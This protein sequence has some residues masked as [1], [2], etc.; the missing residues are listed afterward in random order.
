MSMILS[1][2]EDIG[3]VYYYEWVLVLMMKMGRWG[4]RVPSEV[5][6]VSSGRLVGL[7]GDF[8]L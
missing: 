5:E 8:G 1:G 3:R 7:F 4:I 2:Y 6:S